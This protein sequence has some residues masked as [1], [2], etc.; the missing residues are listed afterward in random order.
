MIETGFE[1]Y[2]GS[3]D[4]VAAACKAQQYEDLQA[5]VVTAPVLLFPREFGAAEITYLA[6]AVSTITGA[7]WTF[8][9]MDV[10]QR[11]E[12]EPC[13]YVDRLDRAFVT[14]AAGLSDES[15][16]IMCRLW[17]ET[18]TDEEGEPPRWRHDQNVKWI[19]KVLALC[20]DAV[21]RGKD[22][23]QLWKF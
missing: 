21:N 7:S 13:L 12:P 11:R 8:N 22:V 15:A 1:L 10:N 17:S 9:D 14:A 20:R 3:L 23:L 16:L 6:D 18:Y 4:V 2:V 19:A 5:G